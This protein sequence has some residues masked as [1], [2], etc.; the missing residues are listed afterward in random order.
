MKMKKMKFTLIIDNCPTHPK[1][2]DIQAVNLVF[3]PHN[4]SSKTQPMDQGI[5]QSLMDQCRKRVL[6]KYINAIDKVQTLFIS[7][8]DALHLQALGPHDSWQH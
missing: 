2:P 3:L 4:T 5:F 6:I 7:I 8:L 1:I